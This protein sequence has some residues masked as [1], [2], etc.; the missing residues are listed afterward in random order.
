LPD[1]PDEAPFWI[2]EV[3]DGFCTRQTL[4]DGWGAAQR[5]RR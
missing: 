2:D 4:I 3:V 1:E 5:E